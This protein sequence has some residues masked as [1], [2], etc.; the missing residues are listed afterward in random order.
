MQTSVSLY[1]VC[2]FPSSPVEH[3]QPFLDQDH[4]E[5]D[6]KFQEQLAMTARIYL[7]ASVD[8]FCMF[9]LITPRVQPSLFHNSP[10]MKYAREY[11][12]IRHLFYDT[13]LC[14]EATC[15]ASLPTWAQQSRLFDF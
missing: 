15:F 11:I 12:S 5:V 1:L 13:P 14:H 3:V 2:L 10:G 7:S 8:I 9:F 6:L 4:S